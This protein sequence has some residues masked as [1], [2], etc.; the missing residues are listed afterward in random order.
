VL[1]AT[2]SAKGSRGDLRLWWAAFLAY[3]VWIQITG[4]LVKAVAPYDAVVRVLGVEEA[5]SAILC[6]GAFAAWLRIVRAIQNDH[7]AAATSAM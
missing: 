4:W 7:Q 6:I 3:Q 5:V 2:R 1:Y